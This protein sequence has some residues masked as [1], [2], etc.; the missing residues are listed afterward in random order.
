MFTKDINGFGVR[1]D[2]TW[3]SRLSHFARTGLGERPWFSLD[4][5]SQALSGQQTHPYWECVLVCLSVG[6]LEG[7]AVVE[8]TGRIPGPLGRGERWF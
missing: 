7:A 5:Q 3:A 8:G 4:R 2:S 1:G 6:E